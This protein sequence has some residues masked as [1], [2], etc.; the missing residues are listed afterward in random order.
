MKCRY[1]KETK[2]VWL[3]SWVEGDRKLGL[4][5]RRGGYIPSFFTSANLI[6]SNI[7]SLIND[8]GHWFDLS[9]QFFLNIHKVESIVVS[10]KV[11]S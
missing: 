8:F 5:G 1:C 11:D 7:K 4:S 10:D 2:T 6:L 9:M 3:Q